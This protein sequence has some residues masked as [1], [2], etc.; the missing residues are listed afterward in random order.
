MMHDLNKV[1]WNR[2][3]IRNPTSPMLNQSFTPK[4]YYWDYNKTPTPTP[5]LE[6]IVKTNYITSLHMNKVLMQIDPERVDWNALSKNP[7]AISILEANVDK[8]DWGAL[9]HNPN[10]AIVDKSDKG[11]LSLL[12][13]YPQKIHWENISY[14]KIPNMISI[15][16][17]NVDELDWCALSENPNAIPLLKK[18]PNKINWIT[19]SK[20]P[21]PEAIWMI[22]SGNIRKADLGWLCCNP[23]AEPIFFRLDYAKMQQIFLPISKEI[24]EYVFHP[25]RLQKFADNAGIEVVDYLELL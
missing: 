21:N 1:L 5:N 17:E 3:F 6:Q 7:L 9:A 2:I 13:K 22:M 25:K 11:D 10:P 24:I 15:W 20:N 4:K 18:Y 12:K 23:S 8:I 14:S 19:L 16:E